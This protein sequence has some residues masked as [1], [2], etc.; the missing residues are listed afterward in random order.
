MKKK[1]YVVHISEVLGRNVII[2][3]EDEE[4]ATE[5]AEELCNAGEINL[6]GYDFGSRNVEVLRIA[7]ENDINFQRY[8]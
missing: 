7:D 8:V 5:K 4:Q 6:D 3:A 2:S 1:L